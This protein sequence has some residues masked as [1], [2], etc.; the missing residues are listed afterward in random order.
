MKKLLRFYLISQ[1]LLLASSCIEEEAETP[2]AETGYAT[3]R[4]V[5][6]QGH[7][8]AGASIF[9]DNTIFFN[10]GMSATTDAQGNYKI[11]TSIGSWRTYAQIEKEYNGHHF[12][13]DLHPDKADSFAG[14]EGAVR[15]FQWKLT[16]E[17]PM[18]PGTFYGGFVYLY[19][20][21]DSEMYDVENIDFTFTPVGTAI[22][23]STL[24]P[25]TSRC[26]APRTDYYSKIPDVPIGRYTVT[27]THAPTQ[28][29]LQ[30]RHGIEG[31]YGMEVTLDFYGETSPGACNNCMYIEYKEP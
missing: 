18:N 13:I 31:T 20:D 12:V 19:R 2:Q 1:L 9:V 10:S 15:N 5:D 3:G 16:G 11:K 30:V 24:S 28:T 21:P 14:E 23:G 8:I 22:D 6:T 25:F 26:G 4:V 7:P 17:N 27:A 29:Q